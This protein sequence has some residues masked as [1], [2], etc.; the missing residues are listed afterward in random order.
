MVRVFMTR[1]GSDTGWPPAGAASTKKDRG[2]RTSAS[3]RVRFALLT[4]SRQSFPFSHSAIMKKAALRLKRHG[5]KNSGPSAAF[6]ALGVLLRSRLVKLSAKVAG[7]RVA[8]L[9]PC[10]SEFAMVV[11]SPSGVPGV[12]CPETSVRAADHRCAVSLPRQT[13][14]VS[15]GIVD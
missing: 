7:W 3:R 5:V 15:G 12:L 4:G 2:D 14:S 13:P 9:L 1:S 8:C 11:G 10:R 6:S